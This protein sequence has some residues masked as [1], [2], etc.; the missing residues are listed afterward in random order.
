MAL[1]LALSLMVPRLTVADSPLRLQRSFW[2][3]ACTSSLER[4]RK[5]GA[6]MS[7]HTPS[8]TEQAGCPVCHVVVFWWHWLVLAHTLTHTPVQVVDHGAA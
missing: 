5:G 7:S 2:T 3:S 4:K 8:M 1:V 6:M